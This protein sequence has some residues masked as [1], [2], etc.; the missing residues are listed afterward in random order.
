MDRKDLR[1]PLLISSSRNDSARPSV[2]LDEEELPPLVSRH[3]M[4]ELLQPQ[5]SPRDMSRLTVELLSQ[6]VESVWNYAML[7][8]GF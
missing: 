6:E 8:V 3:A 1:E 5:L 4:N 7:T 2:D